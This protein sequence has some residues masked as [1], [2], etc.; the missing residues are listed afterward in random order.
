MRSF[1]LSFRF[2]VLVALVLSPVLTAGVF[3]GFVYSTLE[4]EL[5]FV[6]TSSQLDRVKY[7]SGRVEQRINSVE[8]IAGA[9]YREVLESG[10]TSGSSVFNTGEEL[11]YFAV[12]DQK[13]KQI[14]YSRRRPEYEIPDAS[15][16]SEFLY[17]QNQL[18]STPS[19]HFV[20]ARDEDRAR[21]D[22]Y[23]LIGRFS[24]DLIPV[25]DRDQSEV[26]Y[27]LLSRS[28]TVRNSSSESAKPFLR[29]PSYAQ[30]VDGLLGVSSGVLNFDGTRLYFQRLVGS[31]AYVGLAESP[32]GSDDV[33]ASQYRLIVLAMIA[34]FSLAVVLGLFLSKQ[35]SQAVSFITE[36]V[37]RLSR[38]DF[39]TMIPVS[40]RDE[41]GLLSESFNRMSRQLEE[42]FFE[43]QEKARLDQELETAQ[44]VQNSILPSSEF[45]VGRFKVSTYY[46]AAARIGGDWWNYRYQKDSQSLELYVAD[47]TGH[48][49]AAALATSCASGVMEGWLATDGLDLGA[50]AKMLDQALNRTFRGEMF[51]TAVLAS[52]KD[53]LFAYHIA[54][55]ES[56]IVIRKNGEIQCVDMDKPSHHLGKF[57][58]GNEYQVEQLRVK[59]GDKIILYSDGI[60]E[61]KDKNGREFSLSQFVRLLKK[62]EA[63]KLSSHGTRNEVL[64]AIFE[65]LPESREQID[66]MLLVVVELDDGAVNA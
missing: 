49:P 3:L 20:D 18:I 28:A 16:F 15:L 54:A 30:V 5:G 19:G 57:V 42:L 46:R 58:D 7:A 38:G 47:A 63:H 21:S 11:L 36:G 22:A 41:L 1:F 33:R 40:G 29:L 9:I 48:G 59:S 56:I 61:L 50:K 60:F 53:D 43:S 17:G 6:K 64:R 27:F 62:K 55:H 31:N 2:K 25:A 35:M 52:F 23:V 12:I 34:M 37:G 51:M 13:A 24:G 65:R 26:D 14:K 32:S 45:T 8:R 10:F 44:I 66:D 4:R 39:K